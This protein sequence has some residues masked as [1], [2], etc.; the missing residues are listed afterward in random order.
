MGE[1]GID[2]PVHA[3]TLEQFLSMSGHGSHRDRLA[4]LNSSSTTGSNGSES[5]YHSQT[6]RRTR[7]MTFHDSDKNEQ[8]LQE[9][10]RYTRNFKMKGGFKGNTRGSSIQGPFTTLEEVFTMLPSEVGFNIELS[11]C[12]RSISRQYLSDHAEY[13]MLQESEEEEMDTL[14]IEMNSWVDAGKFLHCL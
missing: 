1:T 6:L 8:Q 11:K 10:M 9:R 7:S 13:P 2:A 14:G 4:S 12:H 3:L 5:K